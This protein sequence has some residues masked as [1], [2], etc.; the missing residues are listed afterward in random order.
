[1]LEEKRDRRRFLPVLSVSS[2]CF[3]YI[4]IVC[5]SEVTCIETPSTY[6]MKFYF[7]RFFDKIRTFP[8]P[9]IPPFF[10]STVIT[11]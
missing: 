1:M 8:I 5:W 2:I 9:R 3:S 11:C 6:K 4:N 7:R 10:F